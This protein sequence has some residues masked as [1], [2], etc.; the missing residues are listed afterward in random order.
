MGKMLGRRIRRARMAEGLTQR[1]VAEKIRVNQAQVS[2]WETGRAEPN[3]GHLKRMAKLLGDLSA[4][5]KKRSES[6]ES[7]AEIEAEDDGDN[8][9]NAFG[10]WLR[11]TRKAAGLSRHE[12]SETSGVSWMAIR[13]IEAG[14]TQNPQDKTRKRLET[15][16]N[17]TVPEDIEAE[18]IEERTIKGLGELSDFDPHAEDD[19]P[20]CAGVY[21]FYDI[22]N[23]PIYI[24]QGQN[25]SKRV[26]DHAEKF[27][28]KR[29][30]V[31]YAAYIEIVDKTL[32]Y[33][34]EQV[35]IKFLKSNAV[36]NKQSV[37]RG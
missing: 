17:A 26:K 19:I 15:A 2:S 8:V 7:E 21:V 30:I 33:Q 10:E 14:N 29:P 12:L 9:T 34:V 32:R 37:E 20:T 1:Q 27:W 6:L 25:I 31:H 5:K 3:E 35:L 23:R 28:Y 22:S 36:I 18:A 4:P 16:L 13:N 24:G 11:D